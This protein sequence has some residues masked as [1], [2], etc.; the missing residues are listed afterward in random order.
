MTK[1]VDWGA[2]HRVRFGHVKTLLR[3]RYGVELPDDDAGAEDLRILLHVK[4]NAYRPERRDKVLL[5]EIELQ[6]PW[7][8]DGEARQLAAEIALNPLKVTSDWLG[9]AL[10]VDSATRERLSIWQ[11]GAVDGDAQSRKERRQQRD[12]ERKRQARQ[13]RAEYRAGVAENSAKHSRPWE[14]LGISRATYY[15]RQSVETRS[16]RKPAK[17]N[18][19]RSVRKVPSCHERTHRVSRHSL[20]NGRMVPRGER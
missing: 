6:A 11:I 16:V 18:E 20:S 17:K 13:P 10:N 4:A 5:G 15:R 2:V 7:M 19:T 12:R 9:R 14:A 8:P 3:D 1:P